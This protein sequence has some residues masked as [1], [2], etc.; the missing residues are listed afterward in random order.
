MR[1][2]RDLFNVAAAHVGMS[3]GLGGPGDVKYTGASDL[4]IQ[5][6][7]NISQTMDVNPALSNALKL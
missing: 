3:I 7:L 6:S 5:Q 1:D 2:H 4:E